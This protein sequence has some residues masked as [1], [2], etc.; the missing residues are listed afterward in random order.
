MVYLQ[1]FDLPT[2]EREADFFIGFRRTCFATYY[3]FRLFSGEKKLTHLELSDITIF[4]GGNGS[5]KST[6]LNLIA[7]KLELSRQT[8]FNRTYFFDP[9]LERCSAKMSDLCEDN[10]K[11][12][13]LMAVSKIIT[14]DDVF[15]HIIDVR[16][17]NEGQAFKRDL[18]FDHKMLHGAG[19]DYDGYRPREIHIGDAASYE[20]YAEYYYRNRLSQSQ[21]VKRHIGLEERT[22]SNGENG[23]R[24]FTDAIQ[25][26]G[27]YL[28]DEP[29]NSLSPEMQLELV[30]FLHGMARHYDCQFVLS[31]HSPFLLSLPGSLIY[32]MDAEPVRTCRWTDLPN[33]KVYHDFFR[34]H[35]ADFPE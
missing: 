23:Y 25:P 26:G 15:S 13:E 17:R 19:N 12:H 35:Q 21:Y 10:L 28:L 1:S 9:Y 11:K 2:A 18:V 3:P 7:E 6:L 24:Y 5:G 20:E 4:A 33:M 27:L 30:H 31:S 8:V 32:D 29:E 22:F 34:L 16:E 14:S